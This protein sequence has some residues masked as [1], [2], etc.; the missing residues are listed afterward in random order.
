MSRKIVVLVFGIALALVFSGFTAHAQVTNEEFTGV[1][2]VVDTP[3]NISFQT[4]PVK[5]VGVDVGESISV[6]NTT[7][8]TLAAGALEVQFPAEITVVST[9]PTY[10]VQ[11]GNQFTWSVPAL[12]PGATYTAGFT[13]RPI[14]TDSLIVTSARYVSP[15][16][17]EGFIAGGEFVTTG[18]VAGAIAGPDVGGATETLPRTGVLG[19]GDIG[20]ALFPLAILM[21]ALWLRRSYQHLA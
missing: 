14:Q 4:H 16:S 13:V 10:S 21:A 1:V 20:L 9:S 11:A 18:Q 17:D 15:G 7:A 6:R 19:L 3:V 5:S 12:A 8:V 2:L